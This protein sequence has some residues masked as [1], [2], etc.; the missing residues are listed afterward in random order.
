[1]QIPTWLATFILWWLPYLLV[2]ATFAS[3]IIIALIRR[4]KTVWSK[5]WI[6]TTV[7]LALLTI[8]LILFVKTRV[9]RMG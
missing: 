8:A 1:M 7:V 5:A 6:T 3:A 9:L 4:R 2:A